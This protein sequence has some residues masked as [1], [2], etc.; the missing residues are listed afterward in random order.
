MKK[1]CK[2]CEACKK[3]FFKSEPNAYVCIGVPKPF[4]V[5]S[6]DN[7]CSEYNRTEEPLSTQKDKQQKVVTIKD[8][9]KGDT[10]YILTKNFG[11]NTKPFITETTVKSVG[12]KYVT[13]SRWD[14]K[15]ENC[16]SEYLYEVV[17]Y[18]EN[19]LLFKTEQEVKDYLEK[20]DLALWLGCMSVSQAEKYSLEQLRRVKEILKVN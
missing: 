2:D 8:Y 4:I 5:E 18:G 14:R 12:R 10:A 7:F 9:K 20:Q 17:N 3:G 13:V 11:R 6:I 15:F 16:D 1:K 19:G